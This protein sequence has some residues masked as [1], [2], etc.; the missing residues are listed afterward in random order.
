LKNDKE[1]GCPF[2]LF[3]EGVNLEAAKILD[4]IDPYKIESNDIGAIHTTFGVFFNKFIITL[5]LKRLG[6]R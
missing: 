4:F 2:Y 6:I 5:R 3:T 1:G